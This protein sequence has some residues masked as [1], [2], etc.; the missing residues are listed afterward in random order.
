VVTRSSGLI[1][2]CSHCARW[3][4]VKTKTYFAFRVDVLGGA[5]TTSSSTSL[6]SMISNRHVA[7]RASVAA[8]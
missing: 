6:G 5:V 2:L 3:A 8:L 4:A 7:T 1:L